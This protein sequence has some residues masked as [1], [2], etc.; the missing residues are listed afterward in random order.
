MNTPK[1]CVKKLD[2]RKKTQLV[3]LEIYSV[4]K[5]VENTREMA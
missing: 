4:N 5:N 3:L 1:K 2:L